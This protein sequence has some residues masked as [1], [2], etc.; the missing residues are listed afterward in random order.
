[1]FYSGERVH[2][3]EIFSSY[4]Q[5]CISHQ[6]TK[7]CEAKTDRNEKINKKFNSNS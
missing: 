4:K 3:L 7:M 5:I 2:S 6:S 1:M